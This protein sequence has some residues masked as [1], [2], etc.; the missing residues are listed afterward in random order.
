[1]T[2]HDSSLTSQQQSSPQPLNRWWRRLLQPAATIT[3]IEK[4][5][6]AQLIG[7]VGL[8][9]S[10]LIFI[11][12][13]FH[14]DPQNTALP[15]LGLSLATLFVAVLSRTRY[16]SVGAVFLVLLFTLAAI[17]R[18]RPTQAISL[19]IWLPIIFLLASNLLSF[20]IGSLV[21]LL[22][23]AILF[24][25]PLF[26]PHV[27][28]AEISG[29]IGL[30]TSLGILTIVFTRFRNNTEKQRLQVLARTSQELEV[31]KDE[32][33][34]RVKTRTGELELAAEIGRTV[35]TIRDLNILLPQ[36]VES[37]GIHFN[38]YYTQIYLL[39]STKKQLVLRAGTGA[40]GAELLSRHHTLPL[41]T[42][43]VN[44]RAAM[45]NTAVLVADTTASDFFQPNPLLP[46][47]RCE[48]AVPL[49]IG[50]EV[51]GV[52]DL[53]GD[54]PHQL[55]TDNLPVFQTLAAQLAVAIDNAALFTERELAA[56]ELRLSQERFALA[57]E[58]ANDGLW[59]W[60]VSNNQ[61][62]L[63]P[64]WKAMLGYE[65]HEMGNA[66]AE[67]ESRLHPDDH[68][69]IMQ[70]I[71][72]Y[73]EGRDQTYEHEFRMKHKDGS[74]RWILVR[75][76]LTR[77]AHGAP[78]RMVGSHT[79]ITARKEAETRR[80]RQSAQLQTIAEINTQLLAINT[81]DEMLQTAVHLIAQ[82]F[83]LSHACV[84]LPDES[85][86]TLALAT[87][88]GT[89][90]KQLPAVIA[91]AQ[92]ESAVAQAARTSQPVFHRGAAGQVEL[93]L[94]L[95]RGDQVTGVL[96]LLA[97]TPAALHAEDIEV[98]TTL[99]SQVS[100]ELQS[101][102]ALEETAAAVARANELTRRLTRSG[103]Q[104]FVTK[105]GQRLAF[106]YQR[107]R[108]YVLPTVE[109]SSETAVA[110]PL[111]VRGEEI[112]RLAIAA[113]QTLQSEAAEI[114]AAIAQRLSEHLENLRLTQQ[115]QQALVQTESLYEGSRRIVQ[116]STILE[117]LQALFD[118][119]AIQRMEHA[120]ILFFNRPWE[121]QPDTLI[122]KAI[123]ARTG[124]KIE[125]SVGT[126][127]PVEQYPI[128]SIISRDKQ[129]VL[130]NIPAAK[131]ISDDLRHL[132]ARLD[133]NSLIAL[134]LVSADRWFGIVTAQSSQMVEEFGE[135]E[136]R[137]MRS[138]AEQ[139]ASV[140]RTQQ[141]LE[142]IQGKAA[143]EQTL[144]AIT[145]QVYAAPTVEGV[146]RT[147][148]REV[149]RLL[150]LETFAYL[151]GPMETIA[152]SPEQAP[153]NGHAPEAIN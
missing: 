143:M 91:F 16:Y 36:A 101:A 153:G 79:D 28:Y 62:Y 1:M 23:I 97:D 141:L 81:S 39:S 129:L 77:D 44:G 34:N 139:A 11:S 108:Q 144:R 74:Y 134:P 89:A 46:R 104:Q 25:I 14:A 110:Q 107:Q 90:E 93:A 103:W 42:H 96:L 63:S 86:A 37:I 27:T 118:F 133:I 94:P 54:Q 29:P 102:R 20:R 126:R 40:T 119:T 84:Y 9:L 87:H 32:L 35:S 122:V 2:G 98:M 115:T 111:T 106:A 130:L 75:A 100:A 58:G 33:E 146:L 41:D 113:P 24:L 53:Q 49:A 135:E 59:D 80:A 30:L 145:A 128:I 131:G 138:L 13:F 127:I 76:T 8:S 105:K 61:V 3:E 50:E 132:L 136:I 69:R 48:L 52:L 45:S 149:N 57:V 15:F 47:T 147:A 152:P 95:L 114:T 78:L 124:F 43:S 85:G 117:V 7:S 64:R 4:R 60:D 5:R 51:I 65:D 31:L 109:I 10:L 125:L 151:A 68:D 26:R 82:K 67:F 83:N 38:L 120:T 121:E 71:N 99:A 123:H 19:Y 112:G 150:G 72:D 17:F 56:Q 70:A 22:N 18:P 55:G 73:L 21:I 92:M 6:Q 12:V 88:A 137:Q 148:T 116:A 142:E 140:L 66:F